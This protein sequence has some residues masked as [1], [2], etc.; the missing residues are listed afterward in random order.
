[1]KSFTTAY[2]FRKFNPANEGI[3]KPGLPHGVLGQSQRW[4]VYACRIWNHFKG[5]WAIASGR[6]DA[7]RGWSGWKSVLYWWNDCWQVHTKHIACIKP[8]VFVLT[9]ECIWASASRRAARLPASSLAMQAYVPASD[10][11]CLHLRMCISWT[12]LPPRFIPI[13]SF[14]SSCFPAS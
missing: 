7:S 4:N 3:T 6:Q 11:V 5:S 2:L 10:A 1:M 12:S 13:G 14:H 9:L 8:H